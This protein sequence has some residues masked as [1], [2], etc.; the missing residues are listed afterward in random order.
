MNKFT[1]KLVAVCAGLKGATA[2]FAHDGH[3]LEGIHWH[4]TD[5]WG[6]VAVATM[7]AV[8]IWISRK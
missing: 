4:A 7:V 6:F 8:A 5:T 2:V 3:G 1:P